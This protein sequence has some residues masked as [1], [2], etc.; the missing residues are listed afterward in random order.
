[1]DYRL[2]SIVGGANEVDGVYNTWQ[3]RDDAAAGLEQVYRSKGGPASWEIW[4]A[5]VTS[6]CN[7][8]DWAGEE[9]V[10]YE[11]SETE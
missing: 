1:M 10:L 6:G 5:D 8:G 11:S 9:A 3:T 7:V 2:W 4:I